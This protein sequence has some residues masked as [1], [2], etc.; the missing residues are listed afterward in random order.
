MV[1]GLVGWHMILLIGMVLVP[2]VIV[3]II[4]GMIAAQFIPDRAFDQTVT[5]LSQFN[6]VAQAVAFAGGLVLIDALGPAGVAPF[7]YFQF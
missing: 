3:V 6:P 7:I 1:Q 5:R 4:V 2:V